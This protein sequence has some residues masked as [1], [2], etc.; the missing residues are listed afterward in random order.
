[1]KNKLSTKQRVTVFID[2]GLL[3][4]AKAQA[5]IEEGTL[6]NLIERAL[7]QYLPTEILIIKPEI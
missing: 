4:Q 7:H 6:T 1:M 5:L 2:P 3:K